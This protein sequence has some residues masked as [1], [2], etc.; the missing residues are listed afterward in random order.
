[1]L[2]LIFLAALLIFIAMAA[3]PLVAISIA[4][5]LSRNLIFMLICVLAV[6]VG[7]KIY[8]NDHSQKQEICYYGSHC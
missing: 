4:F 5:M 6:A 7:V 8:F 1:M 2:D 3:I